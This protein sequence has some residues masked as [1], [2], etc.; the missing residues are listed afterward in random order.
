[1]YQHGLC[2]PLLWA[3]I[4]WSV[5]VPTLHIHVLH[6]SLFLG[7][8]YT[9]L[10]LLPSLASDGAYLYLLGI[11]GLIKLGTGC[12]DTIQGHVYGSNK[13]RAKL[14]K[15]Q[16][17]K[18]RWLGWVADKLY[19]YTSGEASIHVFSTTTLKEESVLQIQ[20]P[21][22]VMVSDGTRI[23]AVIKQEKGASIDIYD[24][25]GQANAMVPSCVIE[26]QQPPQQPP[27]QG[28]VVQAQPPTEVLPAMYIEKGGWYVTGRQLVC[29]LGM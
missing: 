17:G 2:P 27:Q 9:R 11:E 28:Q 16:Y 21:C 22:D 4:Q 26:M 3:L 23:F 1:M 19:V 14:D 25:V 6:I 29:V 20:R 7:N 5:Q 13:S 24:P 18:R 12:Q 15:E 8:R 10:G